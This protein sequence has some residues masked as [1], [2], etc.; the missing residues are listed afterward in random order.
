MDP[1]VTEN[2]EGTTYFITA[3]AG[4]CHI[5][6]ENI[7][8]TTHT[9]FADMPE[10]DD[11]RNTTALLVGGL[12]VAFGCF[13][14]VNFFIVGFYLMGLL[15]LLGMF[16]AAK[17]LADVARY[18][19]I[20]NIPRKDLDKLSIYN[21]RFGYMYLLIRFKNEKGKYSLKKI[22]MYDSQQNE[23]QAVKLLRAQG[24]I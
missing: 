9:T 2:T 13:L 17:Q 1:I 22:K 5:L 16:Y 15:F 8:L 7:L 14:M 24:L 19:T 3:D 21:P 20:K 6:P 18:S 4:Y 12:G 23:L 10:P 11:K